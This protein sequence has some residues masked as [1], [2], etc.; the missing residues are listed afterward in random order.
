MKEAFKDIIEK[1]EK[2]IKVYKPDGKRYW[3][4]LILS[5]L[6]W[7]F[8]SVLWLGMVFL[9]ILIDEGDASAIGIAILVLIAVISVVLIPVLIFG[10]LAYKNR[11]YA[12]SNKRILIRSG[13]IGVDYRT[14]EFQA[15]T[16]TNVRVTPLDKL[17]RTKTGTVEFG[18]PSSPIGM[19]A[20]N[21]RVASQYGFK[22]IE[23]PY[24][25]LRE[26]KEYMDKK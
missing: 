10:N 17:L 14:L 11:F 21:A 13:V 6:S 25:T 24:D 9:G 15:M 8:F 19:V 23:N 2:I 12:Y 22:G 4:G 18:S 16:A 5:S 7:V 26:I 3:W 20:G 1:D